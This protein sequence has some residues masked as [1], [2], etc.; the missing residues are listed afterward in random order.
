MAALQDRCE[1]PHRR[2]AADSVHACPDFD[3]ARVCRRRTAC[4]AVA[5]GN[6][7]GL[8]EQPEAVISA[9]AAERDLGGRDQRVVA[10]DPVVREPRRV[11]VELSAASGGAAPHG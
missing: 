7:T 2:V 11:L 6:L 9:P 10:L 4:V 1:L 5:L 8:A 3:A